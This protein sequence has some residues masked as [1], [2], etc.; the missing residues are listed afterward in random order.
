MAFRSTQGDTWDWVDYG[1]CSAGDGY[2]SLAAAPLQPAMII[3]LAGDQSK[4]YN[5]PTGDT[6]DVGKVGKGGGVVG[7]K[8]AKRG[9]LL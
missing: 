5:G 1:R 7:F 4:V 3:C 6:V 2:A 8:V 9:K